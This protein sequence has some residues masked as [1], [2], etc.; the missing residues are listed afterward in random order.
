ME[1]S[2]RGAKAAGG[3]TVGILPAGKED[4][5]VFINIPIATGMG[6]F[7]NYLLVSAADAVIAICGRWGT[8]NEVSLA[9]TLKKPVIVLAGS[10]GIADGMLGGAEARGMRL[11][12]VFATTPEEAVRLA[13]TR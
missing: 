2:A 1:A 6:F 9:L 10:G 8:L 7:R 4:A 3:Q 11:K 12:P 5:N 13:F